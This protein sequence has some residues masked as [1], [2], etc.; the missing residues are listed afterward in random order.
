MQT[1]RSLHNVWFIQ[2]IREKKLDDLD[3][4][5]VKDPRLFVYRM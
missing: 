5:D 1:D 2:S 3:V 4:M